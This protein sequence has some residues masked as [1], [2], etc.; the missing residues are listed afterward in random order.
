MFIEQPRVVILPARQTA[1]L[2]VKVLQAEIREVLGPGLQEVYAAVSA[3]NLV[4]IGSWFLH[5]LRIPDDY[6]EF[7]IGVPLATPVT[8]IGRV[9]A[10]VFPRRR[11]AQAL[12][13]GPYEGLAGAWPELNDWIANNNLRTANELIEVYRVGPESKLDSSRWQT[14]LNRPLLD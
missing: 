4:P 6:F 11:V 12:Y 10:S 3:Q 9:Q 7:E 2:Y 8:P 5:H 13:S 1:T 14:E